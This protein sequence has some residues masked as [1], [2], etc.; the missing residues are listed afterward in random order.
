MQYTISRFIN[1]ISL[2]PK[3]YVL[4]DQNELRLFSLEEALELM[5]YESVEDAE[6]D[7]VF[8]EPFDESLEQA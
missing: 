4:D 7:W 5:G 3:E 8:I 2:N 1:G 6:E